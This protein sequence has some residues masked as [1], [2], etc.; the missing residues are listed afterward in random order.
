MTQLD[1]A[2]YLG[3]ELAKAEAALSN[4]SEEA[5]GKIWDQKRLFNAEKFG[6]TENLLRFMA[7][8][9][10]QGV[11]KLIS[12]SPT[13]TEALLEIEGTIQKIHQI[14]D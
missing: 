8:T 6:T 12:L 5:K 3:R 11:S 2:A 14:R 1:H 9:L 7:G 4:G 13:L 10:R